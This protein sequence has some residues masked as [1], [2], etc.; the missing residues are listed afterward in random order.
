MADFIH[1]RIPSP[2]TDLTHCRWSINICWM[3]EWTN[4]WTNEWESQSLQQNVQG[5][6]GRSRGLPRP[7]QLKLLSTGS[8]VSPN[9]ETS[10]QP[11]N[12]RATL[13]PKGPE[14][15]C[16]S[17]WNQPKTSHEARV[18]A[19]IAYFLNRLGLN[20]KQWKWKEVGKET[21]WKEKSKRNQPSAYV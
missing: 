4:E 1:H 7:L 2:S 13:P 6:A 18:A 20:T 12:A 3:N 10:I 9:L 17:A 19:R 14:G 5:W 8:A 11:V 15:R 21:C 16:P